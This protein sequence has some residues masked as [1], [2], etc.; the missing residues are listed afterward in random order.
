M[1]I[2]S[3]IL[4]NITEFI[5]RFHPVLVHLPIGV[6]LVAALFQWLSS[7]E[8][9]QSLSIAVSIAL[10]WGMISAILSCISGY[11]LS[12]SGDYD[13]DLI[14]NHQ[15]FGI[16]VANISILAY[17]LNRRK[18]DNIWVTGLMVLLIIIT[19]HLGGSITHGSDYLFKAF[20]NSDS[21]A[22]TTKRIPIPDINEALVYNDV[23]RPILT[24]KCYKCHGPDKQKGKLRL[25]MPDLILKGG[26]GGLVLVGGKVDES[27]LIKRIL[28][29]K[30]SDD[31]MPPLEQPQLTKSELDLLHWWVSSGADF[32]KKVNALVQTD[33]IKP[34]LLALQSEEVKE[35]LKLS[36]VPAES[37]EIADAGAI[38]QLQERGIAL[39]AVAQNSNYLFANFVAVE[40]LTE[41]DLQLLD[42]IRKQL[43]WLK[44]GDSN[45]KDQMLGSISAL[46]SLTRLS[47]ER[48]AITDQGIGQ[49]KNLEKLQYL[50]LLGTKVS[51]KGLEQLKSLKELRQIFLFQT[52]IKPEEAEQ[53]KK[54]FPKAMIDFGGYKLQFLE[55]DTTELKD[56]KL[57]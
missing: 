24:A 34:V 26:K 14:S 40:G 5:G 25:D 50:N 51:A 35:E 28:L 18:K 52:S 56:P 32:N 4:E 8:K 47:L 55:S 36:D 39:T 31:H 23:I 49:L 11:L 9:Y 21:N 48:T 44:L 53:L 20:S 17:G 16:A 3:V 37:V 33:K 22:I 41:K 1:I 38:K 7:K 2:S 30:D 6:L 15:W 29:A 57:K 42:P 46:S 45:L 19:G 43:I 27:E 12:N 13:G 10:F 54:I